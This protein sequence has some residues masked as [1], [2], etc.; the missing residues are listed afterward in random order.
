MHSEV[1]KKDGYLLERVLFPNGLQELNELDPINRL[2]E[3]HNV[4][5]SLIFRNGSNACDR[6]LVVL[7]I[8][9][10]KSLAPLTVVVG[11]YCGLCHHEFICIHDLVAL[12]NCL[13]QLLLGN[14]GFLFN[15][16]L[17]LSANNLCLLD[18]LLLN[19]FLPIY[20]TQHV[21]RELLIW[22]HPMKQLASILER[23]TSPI[24]K[25][26]LR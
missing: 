16:L 11:G 20:F 23:I 25:R 12:R 18:L 1:I 4:L 5:W 13:A 15:I 21:Q 22:K 8:V 9:Y 26:L 7:S 2:V 3:S 6:L 10:L 14:D 19:S 24:D 17:F